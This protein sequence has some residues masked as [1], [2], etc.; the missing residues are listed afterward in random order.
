MPHAPGHVI[1]RFADPGLGGPTGFPSP[2]EPPLAGINPPD[3]LL[4]PNIDFGGAPLRSE[5][6][7]DSEGNLVRDFGE[8]DP[9]ARFGINPPPGPRSAPLPNS[10]FPGPQGFPQQTLPQQGFPQQGF[11]QQGFPT[12]PPTGLIGS[13]LALRQGLRGGSAALLRGAGIGRSD[14]RAG[15]EGALGQLRQA[16]QRASAEIAAGRGDLA[17]ARGDISTAIGQGVGTLSPFI[18]PGQKAQQ[19]QAALSGALGP[20]AQAQAFAAFQESPG[21]SFLRE[22]AERATTRNAAAIG[23]LGGGNVRRELQRQAIG[24]AQ[25]DFQNQFNRLGAVTG[26]GLQAAGQVGQLRGQQAGLTGQLGAAGAQLGG[27]GAGIAGQLGQ[28]GAQA[29][30]SR[31]TNLANIAGQTGVNVANLISGTGQQLA[32]GRTRAG[33]QIAQAVGGTTSALSNLLSQQGG[34][35][36]DLIGQ[37]GVNLANLLSA[38]GQQ[39]GTSQEQLAAI[40]ANIATQSGSQLGGQP[41]VTAPQVNTQ[42]NNANLLGALGTLGTTLGGS[43]G[44]GGGGTSSPPPPVTTINTGAQFAGFA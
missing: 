17:R 4:F 1:Q 26:Q 22:Q 5:G 7:V 24:L 6:F 28:A 36:S 10:G 33:E 25:Q 2:G 34:G 27:Q 42:Q 32:G 19:Q 37:G 29:L 43:G 18:D 11:Q 30:L 41:I 16:Q 21:Q 8:F 14:I 38:A 3:P 40:L 44:F 15:T 9:N 12:A 13:E 23:G 31:G 35:I 39:Q 20:E